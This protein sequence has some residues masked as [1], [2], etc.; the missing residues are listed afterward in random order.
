[1]SDLN[2][3]NQPPEFNGPDYV[4]ELDRKRLTGQM[5]KVF[6][7]MRNGAWRTLFEIHDAILE[8]E[9]SISAQLRHLRKEINGGHTIEKRRRGEPSRGL[10]EYKLTVN[11]STNGYTP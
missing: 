5:L 6:S 11:H 9:S 7:Y 2:L 8:P 4:P 1:M 10:W 3:F